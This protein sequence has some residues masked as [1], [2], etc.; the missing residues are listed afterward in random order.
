MVQG[1]GPADG[2]AAYGSGSEV[3]GVLVMTNVVGT[4]HGGTAYGSGFEDRGALVILRFGIRKPPTFSR[5]TLQE[6]SYGRQ[7][8]GARGAR[9]PRLGIHLGPEKTHVS[10]DHQLTHH[11]PCVLRH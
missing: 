9:E 1:T 3:Q 8:L 5:T 11:E 6:Q 4:A 7:A 10:R 2:G